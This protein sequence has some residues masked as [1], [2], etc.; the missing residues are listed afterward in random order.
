MDFGDLLRDPVSFGALVPG[1]RSAGA[2]IVI[3]LLAAWA[4]FG[5][6]DVTS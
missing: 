4:R 6:R 3:F 1:L 2:Y 5:A